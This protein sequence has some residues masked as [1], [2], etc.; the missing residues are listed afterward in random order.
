MEGYW[1]CKINDLELWKEWLV[2]LWWEKQVK[3]KK[4]K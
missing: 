2:F 3:K 4:E 1:D